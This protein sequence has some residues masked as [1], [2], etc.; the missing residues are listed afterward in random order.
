MFNAIDY[1][2]NLAETN[3]LCQEN[4]FHPATVSGPD[5]IEGIQEVFPK[6]KNFVL[7][8]DTT[9]QQTYSKG[10]GFFDRNVYTVFIVASFRWDDMAD[11]EEKM[12]LCRKIFRQFHSKMIRDKHEWEYENQEL[13][14]L[15]VGGVYSKEF[16]RYSFPNLTGLYFMVNNDEPVD[17]TYK[18]EEWG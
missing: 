15:D 11:R 8:D 4:E 14:Y 6:Y 5:G 3:L 9:S 17:L 7:V 18:P 13:E 2:K 12:E 10:V 1:F 16:P